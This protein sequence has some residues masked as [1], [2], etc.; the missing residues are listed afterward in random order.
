MVD[1]NPA[2]ILGAK[3]GRPKARHAPADHDV[4]ALTI[5]TR[6]LSDSQQ[7]ASMQFI[8]VAHP[9][10]GYEWNR[11][12]HNYD[13]SAIRG[14]I[15]YARQNGVNPPAGTPV[16]LDGE[17]TEWGKIHE[18]QAFEEEVRQREEMIRLGLR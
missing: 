11:G 4:F 9:I 18:V 12:P 1:N 3:G 10:G 17:W 8:G 13:I 5:E 7:R 2:A 14:L 15:W 6:H 16:W